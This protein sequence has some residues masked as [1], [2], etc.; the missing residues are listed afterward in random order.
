MYA[1]F[2]QSI[3]L[4]TLVFQERGGQSNSAPVLESPRQQQR[5]WLA[6]L[7]FLI[8]SG[9]GR[10]IFEENTFRLGGFFKGTPTAKM[11]KNWGFFLVCA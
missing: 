7:S 5:C 8:N 1:L 4:F 6:L 3:P 10:G 9:E 11:K 2:L